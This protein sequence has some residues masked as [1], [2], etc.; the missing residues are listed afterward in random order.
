MN[1]FLV[2]FI[3]MKPWEKFADTL[4]ITDDIEETYLIIRKIFQ[5][6]GWSDKD[7]EKPPYYPKDLMRNFQ[8]FSSQRGEIFGIIR[9]YGFKVDSNDV[10]NYIKNKLIKI[11]EITPLN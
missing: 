5:R 10:S 4:N 3:I 1:F 6:E 11:D 2:I 7:L 9:D 8:K